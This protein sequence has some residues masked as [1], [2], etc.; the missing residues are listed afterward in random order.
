MADFDTLSSVKNALGVGGNFHDNTLL[1]YIGEVEGYLVSAGVPASVIGSE[2]CAGIVARGVA[3]L[4][5]YGAGEG[6]LSPYFHERVIQLSVGVRGNGSAKAFIDVPVAP[7]PIHD[8]VYDYATF[9][10]IDNLF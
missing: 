3:D 9:Q 8:D 5:N 4:W 10:D 1:A 6:K 7:L 2:L